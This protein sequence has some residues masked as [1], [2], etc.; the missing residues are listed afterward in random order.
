MD[1]LTRTIPSNKLGGLLETLLHDEN[2]QNFWKE[3]YSK[4]STRKKNISLQK[5][6]IIVITTLSFSK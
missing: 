6:S 5:M 2:E 1:S 3:S 4:P